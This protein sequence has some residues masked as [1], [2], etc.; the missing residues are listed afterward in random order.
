MVTKKSSNLSELQV[1]PVQMNIYQINI[2]WKDLRWLHFDD[3][4]SV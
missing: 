2:C 1:E 4:L 3:E